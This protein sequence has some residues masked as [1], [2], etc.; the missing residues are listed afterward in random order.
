MGGREKLFFQTKIQLFESLRPN[1]FRTF[2]QQSPF[3]CSATEAIGTATK[4]IFF[5]HETSLFSYLSTLKR[6]HYDDLC[7]Y[8][9]RDSATMFTLN[10]REKLRK[11]QWQPRAS[12]C[13]FSALFPDT[14]KAKLGVFKNLF[15]TLSNC[16]W[17]LLLK[18]S[19]SGHSDNTCFTFYYDPRSRKTET[20]LWEYGK[21]SFNPW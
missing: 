14:I 6:H 2:T 10:T 20:M 18:L 12:L 21:L 13:E 5:R 3:L 4:S 9:T 17:G 19:F 1:E 16:L 8:S 15:S 11:L 7:I